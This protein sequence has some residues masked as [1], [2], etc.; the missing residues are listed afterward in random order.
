MQNIL[1]TD[2]LDNL[3]I[4]LV[5]SHPSLLEHWHLWKA[6]WGGSAVSADE[7]LS[8]TREGASHHIHTKSRKA[9]V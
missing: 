2:L 1:T 5:G 6:L 7:Y 8:I 3:G 9:I 4:Y